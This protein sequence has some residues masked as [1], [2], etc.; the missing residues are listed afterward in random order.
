MQYVG[1]LHRDPDQPGSDF[2]LK[3]LNEFNGDYVTAEMV[4][5]FIISGE[6]RGRFGQ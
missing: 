3:K 5:A 2:R 1:Y 4:K 6:H